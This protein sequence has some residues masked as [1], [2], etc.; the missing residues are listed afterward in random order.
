MDFVLCKVTAW[1]KGEQYEP[2]LGSNSVTHSHLPKVIFI[3]NLHNII[4]P[5]FLCFARMRHGFLPDLLGEL[6]S[7][8]FGMIFTI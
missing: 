2:T 3:H 8:I 7:I 4:F 5:K 6:V 1:V